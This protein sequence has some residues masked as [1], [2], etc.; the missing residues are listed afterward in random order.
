MKKTLSYFLFEAI[1]N[2]NSNTQG[3]QEFIQEI[4][5]K[6]PNQNK[7]L[8]DLAT[9]ISNSG[10]PSIKFDT[11]FGAMGISKTDECIIDKSVLNKSIGGLLYVILHE[12]AHQYQY[13]KYGKDVVWD[14]YSSKI[15]LQQA[16]EL[17]MNIETVADKLASLKTKSLLKKNNIEEKSPIVTFYSNM[18]VDYFKNYLEKLRNE[19]KDKKMESIEEVNEYIYNKL[20]TRPVFTKTRPI[21]MKNQSKIDKVLDKLSATGWSSLTDNEKNTLRAASVN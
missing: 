16:A 19:V 4:S 15:D 12:I 9:Y 18:N 8:A 11:L 10:C 20:K 5:N 6:F 1:S 21:V 3:L 17:L 7:L 14:A 13:K 2:T